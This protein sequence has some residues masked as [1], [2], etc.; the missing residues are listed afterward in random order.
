MKRLAHRLGLS[1]H[2]VFYGHVSDEKLEEIYSRA[3]VFVMP[4][5]QGD[6]LPA[7]EALIRGVPVVMHAQSGVSEVLQGTPWVE[8]IHGGNEDLTQGLD[9]MIKRLLNEDLSKCPLPA[10][11]TAS[12]WAENVCR[13]CIW[14]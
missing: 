5:V 12:D 14:I 3:N 8:L 11:P 9:A 6:G 2:T 1:D 4:A 7:L 10:F 13:L